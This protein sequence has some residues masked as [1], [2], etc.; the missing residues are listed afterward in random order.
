[1]AKKAKESMAIAVGKD[2]GFYVLPMDILLKHGKRVCGPPQ[3]EV[4][5]QSL[6]K[7]LLWDWGAWLNNG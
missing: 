4:E 7:E 2:G 3:K 1:M 5:G 6:D